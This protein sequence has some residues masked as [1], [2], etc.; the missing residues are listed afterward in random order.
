MVGL[1][2]LLAINWAGPSRFGSDSG[3]EEETYA[4]RFFWVPRLLFW[5]IL[6]GGLIVILTMLVSMLPVF[7]TDGL[8]VLLDIHRYAGLMT[9]VVLALHCYCLLL[10]RSRL[11]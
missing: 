4:P 10:Q 2:P 5:F 6:A 1:L 11:R 8:L 3:T 9:F 7:G